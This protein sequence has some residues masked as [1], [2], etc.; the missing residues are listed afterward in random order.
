[1]SKT[2][3]AQTAWEVSSSAAVMAMSR[4][5]SVRE[6]ERERT[7]DGGHGRR[8]WRGLE[9]SEDGQGEA[10]DLP[11]FGAV[12]VIGCRIDQEPS[13]ALIEEKGFNRSSLIVNLQTSS[14]CHCMCYVTYIADSTVMN[15]R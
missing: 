14:D 15:L 8:V 3:S 9:S 5:G 1:M 4:S 13:V 7:G 2:P 6:R 12:I 10:W 11:L